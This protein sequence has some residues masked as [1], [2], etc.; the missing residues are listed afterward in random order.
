[1]HTAAHAS[2]SYVT[3]L[4]LI[5][6]ILREMLSDAKMRT[7][8]QTNKQKD[9]SNFTFLSVFFVSDMVA[10]KGLIFVAYALLR[11]CPGRATV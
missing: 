9:I 3:N 7:N 11:S 4:L 1:M 5:L 8:K 10:V 2:Q 6:C